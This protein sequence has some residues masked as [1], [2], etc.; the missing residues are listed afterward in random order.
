[1]PKDGTYEDAEGI[2]RY[3][4]LNQTDK[5]GAPYIDHCIRV[6]AAFEDEDTRI[7]AV[8][9][10]A[11]EDTTDEPGLLAMLEQTFERTI[12]DALLL[13]KHPKGQRYQV[14]I[15]R[16]AASPLATRVKIADITDNMRAERLGRLAPHVQQRLLRKYGKALELLS[17]VLAE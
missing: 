2:A 10:D 3:I 5:A 11:L 6:A 4:H 16:L 15:A 17:G 9:H 7:V 13:L 14:Y 12:V 1:M 8:L